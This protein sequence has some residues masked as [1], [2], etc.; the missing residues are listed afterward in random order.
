MARKP[1][2]SLSDRDFFLRVGAAL[3]IVVFAVFA[4]SFGNQFTNWDD[5]MLIT[6]NAQVTE[7][8]L[9][10]IFKPEP[11]RTYQPIRVLSYAIDY[12]LWGDKPL[13]YHIVNTALH[14]TAAILLMLLLTRIFDALGGEDQ[15]SRHRLAAALAAALF[16]LHPINVESVTWLSS[17]KYGL[18]ASCAFGAFLAYLISTR[19]EKIR[20]IPSA[21]SAILMLL[22]LLS[23]PFAVSLPPLLI[24]FDFCR[25]RFQNPFRRWRG[26]APVAVVV[27]AYPLIWLALMGGGESNAARKWHEDDSAFVTILSMLSVLWDYAVNLACPLF[28]NNKYPREIVRS[29]AEPRLIGAIILLAGFAWLMLRSA[30]KKAPLPLFLGGWFFI[31][32]LPVSN[33]I[34]IST[35]IADRYMYLSAV[36]V[37]ASLGLLLR[38]KQL[39]IAAMVL[40]LLAGVSIARNRVWANSVTLWADSVTKGPSNA[41]AR[42]NYGMALKEIG[43]ETDAGEQFRYAVELHD[44][45]TEA[46]LNLAVHYQDSQQGKL[47]LPHLQRALELDPENGKVLNGLGIYHAEFGEPEEA[48]RWFQGALKQSPDLAAI[49]TNIGRLHRRQGRP[50]EAVA[51]FTIAAERDEPQAHFELGALYGRAGQGQLAFTHLAHAI[52]LDPNYAEA[53][54]NLGIYYAQQGQMPKAAEHFAAAVR[55]KPDYSEAINNLAR[56]QQP[57]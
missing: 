10:D 7:P 46:Q 15:H 40:L 42:N 47:A 19:D 27:L 41:I 16:A 56:T 38:R 32:W 28:L 55:I 39:P 13:G 48:M 6:E 26:Y 12:A 11:G 31:C 53:H 1:Q 36:A 23:S 35:M 29:L 3:A 17:R 4:N 49:H 25:D 20:P 34:P 18:L 50:K 8:S 43:R 51:E 2:T 33:I 22:A 52:N 30:Q 14:A 57:R 54:N 5:R 37:F 45:Y 24:F 9:L 44:A 21:I